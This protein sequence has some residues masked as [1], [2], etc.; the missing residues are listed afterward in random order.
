MLALKVEEGAT[1]QGMLVRTGKA[2]KWVFQKEKSPTGTLILV[3]RV[4]LR[5]LT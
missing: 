4:H 2:G 1:S 3:L 5:P